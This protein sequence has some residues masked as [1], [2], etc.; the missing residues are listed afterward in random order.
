MGCFL[1]DSCNRCRWYP[2]LLFRYRA[3]FKWWHFLAGGFVAGLAC[4]V[5]FLVHGWEVAALFA[6]Y[7]IVFG[8]LHSVAFW[9]LAVWRN[10]GLTS[11]STGPLSPAALA[12]R[13]LAA[14]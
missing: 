2:T 5:P 3:W 10:I 13:P 6:P 9:L 14:G 11:R 4:V 12:R 8:L 7:F 1:Y